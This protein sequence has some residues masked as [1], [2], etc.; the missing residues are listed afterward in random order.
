MAT[1]LLKKNS[2][3]AFLLSFPILCGSLVAQNK[4]LDTLVLTGAF[5]EIRGSHF[6]AGWDFS[7]FGK[8]GFPIYVHDSGYVYRIRISPYGYGR[9]IY[10]KHPDGSFSVYAHLR[11]FAEP[12][13]E[14]LRN[15]LLRNKTNIADIYPPAGKL[16]V[17]RGEIIGFSGNSGSSTGPHLHFELRNAKEEP[18]SPLKF[19]Y[20]LPD[21]KKPQWKWVRFFYPYQYIQNKDTAYTFLTPLFALSPQ[22][23]NGRVVEVPYKKIAVGF[24][25]YDLIG[26]RSTGIARWFLMV[27]DDT[28]FHFKAD[29]LPY[30]QMKVATVM[31]DRKYNLYFVPYGITHASLRKSENQGVI[32][33]GEK[34]RKIEV[35]ICD[36]FNNCNTIAFSVVCEKQCKENPRIKNWWLTPEKD[37][38]VKFNEF[39]VS[40]GKGTLWYPAPVKIAECNEK[41]QCVQITPSVPVRKPYEI[42]VKPTSDKNL[43]KAYLQVKGG[44]QKVITP[45]QINGS[46][47]VFK[48]RT[49]G[50]F[51]LRYDTIKPRIWLKQTD[52]QLK[53]YIQIFIDDRETGIKKWDVFIDGEWIPAEYYLYEKALRIYMNE[54]PSG[55]QRTL[56]VMVKDKTGNTKTLTKTIVY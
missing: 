7:T 56:K 4:P 17:R 53:E 34:T 39:T 30:P 29:R 26:S 27:D 38:T 52:W 41:R 13:E 19:G 23:L 37:T 50:Q 54:P 11:K 18:L 10:I 16:I 1:F 33:V 12:F 28:I 21:N 43:N 44:S 40:I 14:Y 3:K 49:F 9:A 35:G 8:E 32:T 22:K 55:K 48:P 5:G 2:I 24:K 45:S 31:R 46:E 47:L 20:S 6:H 42:V 36:N 15:Y 25:G 51:E